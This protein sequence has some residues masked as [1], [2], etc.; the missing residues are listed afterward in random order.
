LRISAKKARSVGVSQPGPNLRV[1]MSQVTMMITTMI[2]TR[3]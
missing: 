1:V 3:L 2:F